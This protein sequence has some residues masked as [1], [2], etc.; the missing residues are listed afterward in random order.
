MAR[1]TGS[2][3]LLAVASACAL[4]TEAMLAVAFALGPRCVDMRNMRCPTAA[5][6]VPS[7][8]MLV[9]LAE[10]EVLVPVED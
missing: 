6:R 10:L 5:S 8:R 4:L 2:P 1:G 3:I 9:E 7:I